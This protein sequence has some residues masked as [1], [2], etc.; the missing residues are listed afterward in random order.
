MPFHVADIGNRITLV[1][2]DEDN[3]AVDISTASVKQFV[4]RKPDGT[5]ATKTATFTTDGTDG[6]LY[7]LVES[8]LLDQT[9]V[10]TVQAIVTFGGA[11]YHGQF[12]EF[13]VAA[14][15]T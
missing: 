4:L 12:V 9:G 13:A 10:W 5:T 3:A 6:S 14:N 11:T 7:Y 2:V 15:L 1:V 8:G